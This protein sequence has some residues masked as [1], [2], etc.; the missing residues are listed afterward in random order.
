VGRSGV[1]AACVLAAL[2]EDPDRA[3]DRVSRARGC[4]VPDTAE[5]RAWAVRFVDKHL[6]GREG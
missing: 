4:P 6:R 1:L 5:Q 2:G 3:F